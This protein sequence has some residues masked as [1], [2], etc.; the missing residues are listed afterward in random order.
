MYTE[1]SMGDWNAAQ[2]HRLSDPQRGWGIRVLDRLAPRPGER[3]L[4]I[5]CGTGRLT[6]EIAERAHTGTW[7]PPSGGRNTVIGTDLSEAMLRQAREHYAGAAS[8]ARANGMVLPFEREA[9]D[10]VFS[11]ATFH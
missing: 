2:Y 3:I 10:A 8:F 6:S 11:T 5:G 4:D 7:L 9:F 1:R